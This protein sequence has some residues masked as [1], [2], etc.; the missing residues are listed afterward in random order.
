MEVATRLSG[1]SPN[2][3]GWLGWYSAPGIHGWAERRAPG[4]E[5]RPQPSMKES[6]SSRRWRLDW[7]FCSRVEGR[8]VFCFSLCS[9]RVRPVK[10]APPSIRGRS[11][12][13]AS[14]FWHAIRGRRIH[15]DEGR[16]EDRHS[17]LG[18]R[19]PS[20]VVPPTGGGSTQTPQGL[21]RDSWFC[22]PGRFGS[23]L[24]VLGNT[25]RSRRPAT[26]IPDTACRCAPRP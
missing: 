16:S 2:V 20:E 1:G 4:A 23:P 9:G 6:V 21:G 12:G 11:L 8:D 7:E 10:D 26:P 22:F 3:S 19:S 13:I 5:Y 18:T 14:G 25:L 24:M 17:W 15:P